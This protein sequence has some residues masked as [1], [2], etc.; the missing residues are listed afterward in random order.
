MQ[1]YAKQFDYFNSRKNKQND[2]DTSG[3]ISKCPICRQPTDQ[4]YR[5]FCSSRCADIDLGRWLKGG[6]SIAGSYDE[7][8]N[9][10]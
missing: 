2:S 3:L 8:D 6:Y 9:T 4:K 7:T 10:E 1:K 5:P